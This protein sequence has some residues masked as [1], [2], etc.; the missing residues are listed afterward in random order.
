MVPYQFC[1]ATHRQSIEEVVEETYAIIHNKRGVAMLKVTPESSSSKV[2]VLLKFWLQ[3][4]LSKDF[5][6]RKK[7][8]I[9]YIFKFSHYVKTPC[10]FNSW[11][12]VHDAVCGTSVPKNRS[13][14][15]L[16]LWLHKEQV[17]KMV[18]N[19][20]LGRSTTFVSHVSI[21]QNA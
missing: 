8:C 10:L 2:R 12:L 19:T 1:D 13:A 9:K 15:V 14:A 5:F 11:I 4:I 7:F 3:D 18:W 20:P 21:W 16:L 17:R 6:S